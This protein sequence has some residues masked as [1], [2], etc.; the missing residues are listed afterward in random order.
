MLM[1]ELLPHFT[2]G[3]RCWHLQGAG[4]RPSDSASSAVRHSARQLR[5]RAGGSAAGRLR[6]LRLT[7]TQV[8][9]KRVSKRR[10]E[11][12]AG[13]QSPKYQLIESSVL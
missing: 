1:D 11:P 6:L 13:K 7:Q 9:G 2:M 10:R 5:P 3:S 4:C 8:H 12:A